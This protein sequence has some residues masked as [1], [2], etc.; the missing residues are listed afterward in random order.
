MLI[1]GLTGCMGSGKSTAVQCLEHLRIPVHQADRVVHHLLSDHRELKEKIRKRWPELPEN[2]ERKSLAHF[3][4]SH[5]AHVAW[6]ESE[7]HP[8]VGVSQKNFIKQ[9]VRDGQKMIVLDVPLLFETRQHRMCDAIIVLRVSRMLQYQRILKRPGMTSD[10][11]FQMLKYQLPGWQ[12]IKGATY[13]LEGGL[14]KSYLFQQVRHTVE[15][16]RSHKAYQ[17]NPNWQGNEGRR[18]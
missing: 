6:I 16:L 7:L 1:V 4:F 13:I 15:L 2:F 10:L 8:L 3:I 9:C 5:P 17:W 18:G 12:K 11:M 14:K